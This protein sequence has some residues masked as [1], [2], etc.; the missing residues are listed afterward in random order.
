MNSFVMVLPFATPATAAPA[1][2]V[3]PTTDAHACIWGAA[4]DL[5][6]SLLR[7]TASERLTAAQVLEHE[8]LQQ[9]QDE[10]STNP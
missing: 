7:V 8:W 2:F 5:V 3:L 1:C 10:R 4:R 6:R 9:Q